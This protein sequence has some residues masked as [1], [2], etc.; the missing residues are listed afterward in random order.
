MP[1]FTPAVGTANTPP[2][3]ALRVLLI[4]DDDGVRS[5]AQALLTRL[6]H[7]VS[8]TVIE[9]G[10]HLQETYHPGQRLAVQPDIYA[11]GGD[12]RPAT[13]DS[14]ER[15]VLDAAGT[16]ICIVPFIPGF[17]T[18]RLLEKIRNSGSL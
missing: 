11:K 4:D 1:G 7:E 6:G 8:L 17:S 12:Y 9:A 14:E 16:K 5:I 2:R 18:T 10:K 13:L 3:R 15:S